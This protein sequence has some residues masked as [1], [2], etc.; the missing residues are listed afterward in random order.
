MV[1]EGTQ[2]VGHVVGEA[3]EQGVGRKGEV[4]F[5]TKRLGTE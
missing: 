3:V 5:L 2:L 4:A 1:D